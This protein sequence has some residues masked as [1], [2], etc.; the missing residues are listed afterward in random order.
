MKALL[1]A[2]ALVVVPVAAIGQAAPS[3]P[4]IKECLLA[5]GRM[6]EYPFTHT[7]DCIMPTGDAG[8]PCTRSTD[9]ESYCA[10]ETRT[11]YGYQSWGPGCFGFLDENGREVVL[12]V[13]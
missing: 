13:D 3:R 12:C 6:V 1:V 11:C 10:S 5:G 9:C 8:R 2:T 7:R 4:S